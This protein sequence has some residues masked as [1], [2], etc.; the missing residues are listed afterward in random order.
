M[1]VYALLTD[2]FG[3][4]GGI[5]VYNKDFLR[6]LLAGSEDAEVYAVPR[7]VTREIT[8]LPTRLHYRTNAATGIYSY[9]R[10]LI[11]DWRIISAADL[12]YCA[13]LN[14]SPLALL[15]GM[16]FG[17]P[18]LCALYGIEAWTAPRGLFARWA[19]RRMD[20]YFAIS[21]YTREKF[22]AWSKVSIDRVDILPNAIHMSDYQRPVGT[23]AGYQKK[24]RDRGTP[25]LLTFGRLVS[26]DR[27]KGFDEVLDIL[28]LLLQTYPDL[29]YVIAGSG[30]DRQRLEE[31][32]SIANLSK[33][34][35]FTGYVDEADKFDLYRAAD[36][37]VMPS[38]GEGFGFVFL[39]ALACGIPVVASSVDGSRDAVRDGLLGEI[40]DPDNPEQLLDAVLRGLQKER[41]VIPEGLAHFD[42]GQ[43]VLRAN[44]ICRSMLAA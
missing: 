32:V 34:V 20:R 24:I 30:D 1:K 21:R 3:G 35:V 22:L 29:V 27:A 5:S 17:K 8:D 39:E 26:R 41:D 13:H 31:R 2:A 14:L 43:F 7:V 9:S 15:L 25:V 28:P 44:A 33:H 23:E 19:G 37:Y 40:V 36:L 4:H 38:R 18:V 11:A 42:F 16:V 12:I 6:A 10:T